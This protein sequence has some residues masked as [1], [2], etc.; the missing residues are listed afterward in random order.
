MASFSVCA[1][2]GRVS[3]AGVAAK[4]RKGWC[5]MVLK[6]I[7]FAP[8]SHGRSESGTGPAGHLR[9]LLGPSASFKLT[10]HS[11]AT[12]AIGRG[13]MR[14]DTG[15]R[16]RLRPC[17]ACPK[18]PQARFA[19]RFCNPPLH[20][21]GACEMLPCAR[22]GCHAFHHKRCRFRAFVFA[23]PALFRRRNLQPMSDG[24]AESVPRSLA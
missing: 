8:P 10:P 20:H 3:G 18:A 6:S 1:S 19:G 23:A 9:D 22:S 24:T 5:C 2:P 16:L 15:T 21:V 13:R 7:S 17:P 11:G 14:D 12:A 4:S